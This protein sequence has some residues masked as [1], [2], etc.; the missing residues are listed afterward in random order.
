MNNYDEILSMLEIIKNDEKL[1]SLI[2]SFVR[3]FI[4]RYC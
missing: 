2:K 4:K 3:A 1:L